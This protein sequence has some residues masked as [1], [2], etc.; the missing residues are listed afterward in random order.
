M[1]SAIK[2]EAWLQHS[3]DLGDIGA[4]GAGNDEWRCGWRGGE[5]PG[6]LLG[7]CPWIE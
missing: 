3:K 6:G 4:D 1:A 5:T 2:A 7:F